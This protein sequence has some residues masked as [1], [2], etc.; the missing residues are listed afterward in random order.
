[1]YKGRFNR[2]RFLKIS[3][4][5]AIATGALGETPLLADAATTTSINLNGGSSG[6]TF[7][8]VGGLSGGGGTSR[9]L[10]DYPAQQQSEILDYL[11]KPNFGA[12]LHILK[13]EIG[14]DTNST[15]GAEASHMRSRTDQ[16][17]NRGYEW[18]LMGQ[19]K[20][21]NSTIKLYGLEWG[22]PGWFA[23][24]AD[25]DSSQSFWSHDNITYLTNWITNAASVH[26]LHIDYLGGWNESGYNKTWYE[27]LKAA[28]KSNNLTTQVVAS[29]DTTWNVAADMVADATFAA[30][31]DIVGSHY[32]ASY[33]STAD[34][35][36]TGKPLWASESGSSQYNSGA[37]GIVRRVNRDYIAGTIVA[38]IN[39]SLIAAWYPTL[40]FAGDG[41]MLAEQP[42]SG[43]YQVGLSIWAMAHYG[44]FSQPGWQFLSSS[45]GYLGGSASNGSYITLKS[46]N[47]TDYSVIIETT[48]AT[49]AQTAS[50]TISGGLSIGT[51]HVWTTD[52]NSSS[53]SDYFVHQQDITPVSGAFSLTLQPGY[54]Y[55]LTTTTGQAKGT[56][57]PP[58]AA[59]LALPYTE[60]FESYA[61]G[62]LARYYSDLAGAF[63]T[64]S[65]GGGRSGT[66]YRQVITTP[67]I[68]W[69][70]G[71]PTAPLTVIGDP[72]WSNY[73]ASVD[74]LLEQAGYA[75][76][77]GNLTSQIRL[78][79]AAE[80]YHLRVTNTGAWT[81]FS[82]GTSSSNTIVDT[83]LASGTTTIGLNSWHTL[84]L[85]LNSG[86]IEAFID[87]K[88]VTTV[89]DATYTGGQIALLVS[90][91]V[92]AQ[93]DNISVVAA[94]S[95]GGGFNPTTNYKIVNRNSGL[96]LEIP[97]SSTTEGTTIDQNTYTGGKNQLW[98][99]VAEGTGS[100]KMVNVNSG[101]VL[102]DLNKATANAS[103]VGQWASNGATNQE[104]ML[105]LSGGYYIIKNVY[106]GL[107]LDVHQKSTA[108]GATVDQY[109]SN[110]GTNQQW[111]IT[112]G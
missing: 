60:N 74:V 73:Q 64:A 71:S 54:I 65:A 76:L 10:F 7:M 28:L 111:T 104:W 2:R 29:D 11:F 37:A 23:A 51:V 44:Q 94:G 98:N 100:Y 21:R 62:Q 90:K 20:T 112:A 75:E 84:S 42:W 3:A 57:T 19:A 27:D 16:N 89:T 106:S 110:G 43:S 56:T 31:I 32:P 87:G 9:L 4:G 48:Q 5:A 70:G 50:F 83:T 99:L 22:A 55:S 107:V 78:G 77:I 66:V 49:S 40:P 39:W 97:G 69:H 13:V 92:N 85:L 8:G 52:F 15:N 72:N 95:G 79:G 82:E 58:A 103:P 36:S 102:D 68:A 25:I 33:S 6:H 101:L 86:T 63:E 18:W 34:A 91:W 53:Q 93:F 45:C 46:T 61:T 1:M 109:A 35:I 105:T 67:P 80:G 17:Y 108:P 59:A 96:A 24:S 47:A 26:G 12:S 30:S 38:N 88:S 14:G 41:L 81:L